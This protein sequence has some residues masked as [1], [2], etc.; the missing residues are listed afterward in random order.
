MMALAV[1]LLALVWV[2]ALILALSL[3]RAAARGDAYEPRAEVIDMQARRNL[4]ALQRAVERHP[5]GKGRKGD[6]AS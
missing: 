6:A 5:A 4:D 3:A 1:V 2:G